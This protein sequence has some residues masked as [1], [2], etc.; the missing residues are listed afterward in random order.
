MCI[1]ERALK[2]NCFAYMY[3]GKQVLLSTTSYGPCGL[4]RAH[5]SH[6]G[7]LES[8]ATVLKTGEVC[9]G[10]SILRTSCDWAFSYGYL[11]R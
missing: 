1:I 5:I 2:G 6:G 9:P 3:Y 10:R 8:I 4:R 11:R 7:G